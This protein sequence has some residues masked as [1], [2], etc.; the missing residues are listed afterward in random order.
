VVPAGLVVGAAAVAAWVSNG[1][2]LVD[3]QPPGVADPASA[4]R[5]ALTVPIALALFGVVS[6]LVLRGRRRE[7]ERLE[8]LPEP[9]LVPDGSAQQLVA[10]A[11]VYR[12]RVARLTAGA[13]ALVYAVALVVVLHDPFGGGRDPGTHWRQWFLFGRL[14]RG[15]LVALLMTTAHVVAGHLAGRAFERRLAARRPGEPVEPARQLVMRIDGWSVALGIAGLSAVAGVFAL[16][17]ISVGDWLWAFFQLHGPRSGG[18][19][20]QALHDLVLVCVF[21]ATSSLAIGRACACRSRRPRWLGWLEHPAALPIGVVLGVVT[22]MMGRVLDFGVFDI[23]LPAVDRASIGL[24]VALTAMCAAAA[25]LIVGS[26][27]V[28]RRR[29]EQ[30]RLA[31]PRG[32][33]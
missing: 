28:R 7:G 27:T 4:L 15:M 24:Q 13:V 10:L 17:S 5:T 8:T 18:A 33:S 11:G 29:A 22:I 16:L 12:L 14:S 19:V 6:G 31:L 21:V 2:D 30:E 32:D 1:F 20:H 3:L 9:A 26:Y 23:S 25:I